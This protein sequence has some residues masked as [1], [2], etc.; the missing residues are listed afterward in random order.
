MREIKVRAW[1]KKKKMWLGNDLLFLF[2]NSGTFNTEERAIGLKNGL[3]NPYLTDEK[4]ELEMDV[5]WV[6]YTGF[7]DI[8]KRDIYEGDI[9]QLNN[10][11]SF[12]TLVVFHQPIGGFGLKYPEKDDRLFPII[13]PMI[14]ERVLSCKI[15]GNKFEDPE[16]L[17][18]NE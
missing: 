18:A 16:L 8:L 4:N 10:D 6:Q 5:E 17:K 3:Q 15:I 9:L 7:Q 2:A 13:T 12:I 14:I 1:D 11:S